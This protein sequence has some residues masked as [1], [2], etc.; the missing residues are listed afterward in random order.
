[1]KHFLISGLALCFLSSCGAPEE[2]AAGA[3][4][5]QKLFLVH[6]DNLAKKLSRLRHGT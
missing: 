3:A 6:G 5:A 4:P 1:M 2:T